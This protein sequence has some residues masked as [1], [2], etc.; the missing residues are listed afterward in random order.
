[1][2]VDQIAQP[3]PP[4][5][6]GRF[7]LTMGLAPIEDQAW[8]EPGPELAG[9]LAAKRALLATRHAEVFRALPEA[10]AAAAE[11]LGTLARHLPRHHPDCYGRAGDRLINRANGEE[12]DLARPTLH[13]LDLAGRL[14]AEDL[15]LVEA[16]GGRTILTAAS[17][18][19]PNR[20][21]LAEKLGQSLAAIHAPVP[22]YEAVLGSRVDRF[23]AALKPER[24]VRRFNWGIGHDEARFQPQALPLSVAVTSESAGERLWLRVERQTLRRLAATGAVVF[25]IGTTISRLDGVV[26]SP[27]TARALAS[28]LRDMSP[29]MQ[30]YKQIAPFAAPLLAWLDRRAG[31]P[32]ASQPS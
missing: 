3:Y 22:G 6:A 4:F 23:F 15:C 25:T 7:E 18:C 24:P 17:L 14:V 10:A 16:V 31:L 13:P 32:A 26:V 9:D 5:A 12:W 1:M 19:A 29:E 27:D 2:S 30:S 21:L 11:L 28:A 8:L 20:W